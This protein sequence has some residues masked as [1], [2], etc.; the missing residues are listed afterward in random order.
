MKST[1]FRTSLSIIILVIFIVFPAKG[2]NGNLRNLLKRIDSISRSAPLQRIVMQTDRNAYL[3]GDKILFSTYILDNISLNTSDTY[4][5][6]IYLAV[7]DADGN[8]V[9]RKT[10]NATEGKADGDIELPSKINDGL[11]YLFAFSGWMK[12]QEPS[13]IFVTNILISDKISGKQSLRLSSDIDQTGQSIVKVSVNNGLPLD[14]NEKITWQL[15]QGNT[16]AQKGSALVQN[17]S[18]NILISNLVS[19]NAYLLVSTKYTQA[20]ITVRNT[21]PCKTVVFFPESGKLLQ[22]VRSKVILKAFDANGLPTFASGNIADNNNT[23]IS[24]ISTDS[25]GIASFEIQPEADK[26]Y[27]F[28]NSVNAA[29]PIALPVAETSG[30]NLRLLEN[31][32]EKIVFESNRIGNAPQKVHLIAESRQSFQFASEF[33]IANKQRISIPANLF[34]PGVAHVAILDS[35]GNLLCERAVFIQNKPMSVQL[36]N[37]TV[38][39]GKPS[40]LPIS[41]NI[42]KGEVSVSI[43]RTNAIT[44]ELLN[45]QLLVNPE[46]GNLRYAGDS[47]DSISDNEL[48]CNPSQAFTWQKLIV[49]EV[50]TKSFANHD[51]ISGIVVD[52]KQNPVSNATVSMFLQENKQTVKTQ[53]NASGW[54]EFSNIENSIENQFLSITATNASDKKLTSISIS[55][56]ENEIWKKYFPQQPLIK[57]LKAVRQSIR[58]SDEDK[59]HLMYMSQTSVLDIIRILKPFNLVN[60]NKIVFAG[61]TNSI[62]A[63]DGALIVVDDIKLGT[64]CGVLETVAIPSIDNIV[65]STNSMD[66]LRYTGLNSVGVIMITT[67]KG[68]FKE[69]KTAQ[70]KLP[71]DEKITD[72]SIVCFWNASIKTDDNGNALLNLPSLTPGN[73]TITITGLNE[74]KQPQFGSATFRVTAIK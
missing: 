63:Q 27:H 11:Y 47:Q 3:P 58:L 8:L 43:A 24:A 15:I 32:A 39:S 10:V 6:R 66:I 40:K 45:N 48:L 50:N 44:S 30:Y 54:F 59:R 29:Q 28:Q 4:G 36:N 35:A 13:D 73:Y 31:D 65:V 61:C 60:G 23:V 41:L 7:V 14:N 71:Q 17:G 67:K 33:K 46:K 5:K 69:P 37:A 42:T 64:D 16:V 70:I 2:S 57:Q 62:N 20:W 1:I 51:V 26:T 21:K 38:S 74:K 68:K 52:S 72:K 25:K 22:G 53:T 34:T 55:P 49:A 12:N 19:D 56:F 18:A 9:C